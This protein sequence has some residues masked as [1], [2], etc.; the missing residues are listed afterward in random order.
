MQSSEREFTFTMIK[1]FDTTANPSLASIIDSIEAS[2]RCPKYDQMTNKIELYLPDDVITKM[3]ENKE[4]VEK[5]FGACLIR[6]YANGSWRPFIIINMKNCLRANLSEREIAAIVLH[7]LGHILNKPE[8][9]HE[10][11]LQFCFIHG[12]Q[13]N[14]ELLEKV[15][16]SNS[17][18]EEFFADSYA[19]R[20][21]YGKEL[22]STFYKQNENFEQKIG[23]CSTRIEK[24]RNKEYFEGRITL[25][26][27]AWSL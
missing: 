4:Q 12:I 13:F 5:G 8:L 21:G 24:I 2:L 20:H 22:I 17:N 27:S 7:E 26:S 16:E 9:Q 19:N 14:K 11:T 10:P 15:R 6:S 18:Q 25:P 1:R 23:N 3:P